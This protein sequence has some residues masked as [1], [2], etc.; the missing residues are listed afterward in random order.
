[1]END[2]K[3][4]STTAPSNSVKVTQIMNRNV[5]QFA[6]V[7]L[8]TNLLQLWSLEMVCIHKS[9]IVYFEISVMPIGHRFSFFV[10]GKVIESQFWERGGTL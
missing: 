8:L 5:T 6:L 9:Y 7:Y 1:M 10:H 4:M 3:I 2:D